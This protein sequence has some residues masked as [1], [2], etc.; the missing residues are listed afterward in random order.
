[1]KKNTF[2]PL[3]LL[4]GVLL[5]GELVSRF[6]FFVNWRGFEKTRQLMAAE[7]VPSPGFQLC[8]AQPYLLYVPAPHYKDK[9]GLQ[10][11]GQGYRGDP[12]P[13]RRTPGVRRILCLGGST[14]YGWNVDSAQETYPAHLEK[15]LNEN[16]PPGA[17][18]VEVINGGIPSGT[19]AEI[20]THYHFKFHYYKP[21]LI[22][23]NPGG[24]DARALF[25]KHYHPDY[26]HSRRQI[27]LPEPLPPAG[28]WLL[29]SR[30]L[31]LVIV[32]LLHGPYP[33]AGAFY[34]YDNLPPAARWYDPPES[35]QNGRV[36]IPVEEVAFRHNL[37]ALLDEIE[38]DKAKV[39][40]VPFRSSPVIPYWPAEGLAFEEDILKDL[41]RRRNIPL[42][43]FPAEVISRANWLDDCHTNSEG[44]REKALHLLPF[45]THILGSTSSDAN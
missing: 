28:R 39:L 27:Q 45:V 32:P 30:L 41:A 43:P 33:N 38:K 14:T 25:A 24:N 16:R 3:W 18:R 15:L 9:H 36:Q 8:I 29:K 22:I 13:L 44:N 31:S 26:S 10:H 35:G 4:V 17:N 23:I 20:L 7:A 19:T 42:A 1:M 12:V 37:E 5:I 21:D 6:V 2:S 11:N 40:L 34:N